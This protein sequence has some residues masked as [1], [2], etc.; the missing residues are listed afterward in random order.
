MTG[1][2]DPAVPHSLEVQ[3]VATTRTARTAWEG[4]LVDG[5]GQVAFA[6]SGIGEFPVSW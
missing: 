1:R 5:K 6:S 2:D 4:N 3:I